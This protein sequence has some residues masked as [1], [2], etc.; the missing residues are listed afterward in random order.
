MTTLDDVPESDAEWLVV[1]ELKKYEKQHGREAAVSLVR[2]ALQSLS[3]RP[4]L[5]GVQ[6][7]RER[8]SLSGHRQPG[9]LLS[10]YLQGSLAMHT[11]VR[12]TRELVTELRALLPKDE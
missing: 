7:F 2:R 9:L 6:N 3:R 4:P 11:D 5:S 1:K 8:R 10:A 12:R